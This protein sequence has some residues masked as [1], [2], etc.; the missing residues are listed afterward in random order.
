MEVDRIY[1]E[2]A[3]VL[4]LTDRELDGYHVPIPSLC[5]LVSAVHQHL[6]K[7]KVADIHC[8]DSGVRGSQEKYITLRPCLDMGASAINPYLALETIRELVDARMLNKDYY[9]AVE[10]YIQCS[11]QRHCKN[12]FQDWEFLPFS[13]IRALRFLKPLVSAKMSLINTLPI[14]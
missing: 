8:V 14:P 12:C 10:D 5:W 7:T 1:R 9:A 2:G 3:N 6:V 13:P 4:I 11:D